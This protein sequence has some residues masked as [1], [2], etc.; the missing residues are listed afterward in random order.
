MHV[1][2]LFDLH[3]YDEKVSNEHTCN[4]TYKT[5]A[6]RGVVKIIRCHDIVYCDMVKFDVV[7][8]GVV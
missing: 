4:G 6:T 2:Y 1:S 7:Q 3:A 8:C 5:N